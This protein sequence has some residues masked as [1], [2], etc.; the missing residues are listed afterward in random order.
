MVVFVQIEGYSLCREGGRRTGLAHL[1]SLPK[2]QVQATGRDEVDR[3]LSARVPR[4]GAYTQQASSRRLWGPG[5]HCISMTDTAILDVSC[6]LGSYN[7]ESRDKG[8]DHLYIHP[9][10]KCPTQMYT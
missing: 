2:L 5:E 7:S 1:G 6:S 8:H 10:I 3:V 4:S 9:F